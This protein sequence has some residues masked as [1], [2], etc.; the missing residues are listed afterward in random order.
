MSIRDLLS[1]FEALADHCKTLKNPDILTRYV[2]MSLG[3]TI[4]KKHVDQNNRI[5]GVVLD[6]GTE[7]LLASSIQY[8]DDGSSSWTLIQK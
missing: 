4:A 5:K 2:R 6:K 1:I 7:D 3:R 8:A